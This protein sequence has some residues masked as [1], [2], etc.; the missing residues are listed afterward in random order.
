MKLPKKLES[1]FDRARDVYLYRVDPVLE[2]GLGRLR[3]MIDETRKPKETES[4]S[5]SD[6][7]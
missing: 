2:E 3:R 4:N 7:R 6:E 1:V 5:G